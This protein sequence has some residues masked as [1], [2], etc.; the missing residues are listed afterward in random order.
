MTT[1]AVALNPEEEVLRKLSVAHYFCAGLQIFL[2]IIGITFFGLAL[3]ILQF[4]NLFEG[5]E[6]PA[7]LMNPTFLQIGL[8]F[9]LLSIGLAYGSYRAGRSLQ[10]HRGYTL[11]QVVA[12]INCFWLPL[13]PILGVITTLVLARPEV[14]ILFGVEPDTP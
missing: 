9:S 4:P 3:I 14:R 1:S 11:C 12:A 8:G 7:A 2:M 6:A 5:T 10:E 13:G